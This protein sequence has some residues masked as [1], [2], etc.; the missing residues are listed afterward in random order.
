MKAR[1]SGLFTLWTLLL[2]LS[3]S[4]ATSLAKS[5]KVKV[6]GFGLFGNAE[7]KSALRLIEFGESTI[8]AQKTEDGAFLLLTRLTQNGY[9]DAQIEGTLETE[10]GKA[11]TV[12]WSIPFESQIDENSN[13]VKLHY[14]I[15]PGTLYYYNSVSIEGLETI[16]TEE[17]KTYI[18]PDRSLYSRKKDRAYSENILSNHRKQLTAGLSALGRTDAK[19]TA[20][21]VEIDKTS[22]A[23][24]VQ[25]SVNEGPLYKVVAAK[26]R[27]LEEDTAHDSQLEIED[28][29]Y[30]RTWVEDQAKLIRNESYHL[31]YPD[32]KVASRISK[33]I[34]TEDTVSVYL[35]FE[36]ERGP[37]I[38]L[39]KVEHQGA[40]DTHHPLLNRKAKLDTGVPLDITKTEA[41]RRRLSRI[42]IFERIDL[43]YEE[44]GPGQRKAVYQYQPSR[45]T[46]AQLLLGYGSYER[47]RG[48]VLAKRENIFGRAHSLSLS[49][50]KSIKSTSGNVDYT[51]PDLI[52][53]SI[54]G[55][56]EFNILEREELFFDRK[57]RGLSIGL[58]KSMSDLSL[59]VGLDYALD[60]KE[61]SD[62]QFNDSIEFK[63]ADIGSISLRAS[64]TKLDNILYPKSGYAI[65]G[66]IR[67]ANDALGGETEFRRPE[68]S[69][70]YHKRFG[71]RWIF[72]IGLQG[73]LLSIPDDNQEVLPDNE[74]FLVG[75]E[76]SVR[77]YQRG[78]AVPIDKNG[79]PIIQV[80][81]FALLNAELEYPLFDGINLVIFADAAR[82]W[83]SSDN[84]DLYEDFS[85]V[86]LGFRY[87]TIV[88]PVRLEY[89]HNIDPRPIDPD[90]TLHFSIGFP[91]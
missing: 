62:P 1:R 83:E 70:A 44:D 82:V 33:V 29:I 10:D 78:E 53:E 35:L 91:F 90:G 80:E 52:G 16:D 56:L 84:S 13:V 15:I 27:H 36:V 85:S 11:Q 65:N 55:S 7:L 22:G 51:I 73:G 3:F 67:Y 19:V 43:S 9:L 64:H 24:D 87:N 59:D 38:Q 54:T 18:I 8:E 12:T 58:F 76:N 72:H 49:A 40:D 60:K 20:K 61:S 28:V 41:A 26:V 5:A 37:K 21:S 71:D 14:K 77:G 32:A 50:I 74:Y 2:L 81:S 68:F 34:P 31:G 23:V 47:F 30:N 57:E 4:S 63:E 75:G 39:S 66:A 88:G 6:S 48:G 17:A 25:L 69:A 42:G 86:G 79:D 45:R 46:Q 89:G